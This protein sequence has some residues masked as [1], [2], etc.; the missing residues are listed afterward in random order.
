MVRGKV[1]SLSDAVIASNESYKQLACSRGGVPADRVFVVRNGPREGWPRDVPPDE[2]LKAG[3]RHL[4]VYIGVMGY[5][6][7]VDVL[8]QAV[9]TLVHVL[10][11]TDASFA[12]IGDGD[13]T[14][15][16]KSQA[17]AL[18]ID[19]YVHFTGWIEDE[20]ALSRY[21]ATADAC[22]CPEPSS[23]LNDHSTFIK[24]MEYMASATPIVAFDLPETRYSAADAAV[25]AQP[26]DVATF[27]GLIKAALTDEALRARMVAVAQERVPSLRWE[28]QVPSLLAAYEYALSGGAPRS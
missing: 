2:S 26:G 22:V 18:D 10:G 17:S 5:Q 19:E 13:A 24:V 20:D 11:F 21:L 25:Y 4:V 9:H 8:M 15:E 6:D 1:V 3:R 12:V 23:P 14:A 16:L 28:R 7:G 27:A